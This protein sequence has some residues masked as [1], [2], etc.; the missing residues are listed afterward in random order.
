[1]HL[2]GFSCTLDVPRLVV[3]PG[4]DSQGLLVEVPNL[5]VSSIWCLDDHVSVVDQIK[6][7]VFF[8]L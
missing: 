1:L 2:I 7:S 6:V 4:S 5:G 3:I 8:H